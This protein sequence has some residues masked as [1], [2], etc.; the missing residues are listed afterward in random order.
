M[1]KVGILLTAFEEEKKAIDYYALDLSLPE[2]RRT[3]SAVPTGTY[4]YVKCFGLHGT[5]D[6]GLAWLQRTKTPTKSTCVLS[7]GSSIGN[8][9]RDG[10]ATFLHQFA[11]VLGPQDSLIIGLDSC[12]NAQQIYTAYND[13]KGVTESFYRNGLNHA[14]RLLGY[15]G[16]EQ[17][18]W[19]VVGV[20]NEELHCHEAFY[21]ALYDVNVNGMTILKGSKIHLET[22]YKYSSEQMEDL[23][24]AS[25]LVHQTAYGNKVGDYSKSSI[26]H[27]SFHSR[28]NLGSPIFDTVFEYQSGN[29]TCCGL[30]LAVRTC[31]PHI[32]LVN[33]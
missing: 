18:K 8:F 25:G 32:H 2:L 14:N 10:A 9:S 13:S 24:Q 3:L 23:W 15:E 5:Y 1:R 29:G 11:H 33:A 16:F 12:Q 4:Q 17:S 21:L 20:F 22:A 31:I 7:L 6:D 26:K 28:I 30:L 19:D 27:G